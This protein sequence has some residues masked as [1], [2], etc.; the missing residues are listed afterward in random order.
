VHPGQAGGVRGSEP[1]RNDEVGHR[2]ALGLARGV[3]EEALGGRVPA[4]HHPVG[5]DRDVRVGRVVEHPPQPAHGGGLLVFARPQR[6][7]VLGRRRQ[8][9]DEQQLAR[10]PVAGPVVEHAERGQ[11]VAVGAAD[12]KPGVRDDAAGDGRVPGDALVG[13]RVAHQQGRVGVDH[14]PAER[15]LGRRAGLPGHRTVVRADERD[16]SPGGSQ[17]VR[18]GVGQPVQRRVGRVP[19]HA[20]IA[21]AT[22]PDGVAQP[23]VRTG[24]ARCRPHSLRFGRTGAGLSRKTEVVA[25]PSCQLRN[26]WEDGCQTMEILRLEIA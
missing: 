4:R 24:R 8:I 2:P 22:Q 3:A 23:A 15:V 17:L 5:V 20:G 26:Q 13:P 16:D 9:L 10:F 18:G 6:D 1:V 25:Q 19:E 11:R 21:Q 12:G 14:E 7:L